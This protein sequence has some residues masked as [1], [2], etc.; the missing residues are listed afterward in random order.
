MGRGILSALAALMICAAPAGADTG[1]I[2]FDVDGDIWTMRPDGSERTRLTSTPGEAQSGGPSWSPDGAQI[3]FARGSETTSIF[4]RDLGATSE[5]RITRAGDATDE[6]APDWSSDGRT[7]VFARERY[8]ERRISAAIVA[9]DLETGQQR[10]LTKE[11]STRQVVYF[12]APSFSPDGT[13]LLYTRTVRDRS[14]SFA[15]A[16]YVLDLAS[17]RST[18]L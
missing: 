1:R 18:K 6:F 3:A 7:L 8:G 17:G 12:G 16:L 13:R 14:G 10:T 5:R 11:S 9:V 4:V 15:P 2:A